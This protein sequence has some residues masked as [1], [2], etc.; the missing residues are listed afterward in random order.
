MALTLQRNSLILGEVWV[1]ELTR[2]RAGTGTRAARS[3]PCV[4]ID[5]KPGTCRAHG[6]SR[7]GSGSGT[8]EFS[9]TLPEMPVSKRAPP[10]SLSHCSFCGCWM[11]LT[12]TQSALLKI[13]CV[14]NLTS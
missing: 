3:P 14:K 4:A 10:R 13:A 1:T 11:V 2:G 5:S 7:K 6:G 9:A 8:T 12:G